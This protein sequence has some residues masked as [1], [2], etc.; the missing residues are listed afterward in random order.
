MKRVGV[1]VWVLLRL[2]VELLV[3]VKLG[4]PVIV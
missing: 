4:V 1:I 2:A 3:A